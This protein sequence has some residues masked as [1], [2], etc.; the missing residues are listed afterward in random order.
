MSKCYGVLEGQKE[1]VKNMN[2]SK[3]MAGFHLAS[4]R[5]ACAVIRRAEPGSDEYHKGVAA[6]YQAFKSLDDRG[7]FHKLDEASGYESAEDV[8]ERYAQADAPPLDPAEW[9]DTRVG[10]SHPRP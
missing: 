7:V 4:A 2:S 3:D 6:L 5:A 1:K 10:E 8:L 9:G